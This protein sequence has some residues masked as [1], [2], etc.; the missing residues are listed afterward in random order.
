MNRVR[1]IGF[2]LIELLVV[3]VVLALLLALLVPVG[4]SAWNTALAAKCRTNLASM[5]QAQNTWRADRGADFPVT[6]AAWPMLLAPYLE[7]NDAVFRCPAGPDRQILEEAGGGGSGSAGGAAKKRRG[8]YLG[9][10]TFRMYARRDFNP[11][12]T[13]QYLGTA[14]VDS[15]YGVKKEHLGGGK[16]HYGVDDRSFF[17]DKS[18][19]A[20]NLDY[21]DMR[22]HLW[23]ENEFVTQMEII[24][25]DEITGQ[26]SW[27]EFR[28]EIWISDE[29]I[30]NDFVANKGVIFEMP[31]YACV[32]SFDYALNRGLYDVLGVPTTRLDP[33]LF[34]LL[35]YGKSLADYASASPDPWS[36]YFTLERDAWMARHGTELQSG[37]DWTF[38]VAP[39][40]L[41]T[42]NVLFADGH[43]EA[44]EV[45][46]LH[47]LDPRWRF[48][49][50]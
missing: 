14:F 10:L 27:R 33:R 15:S 42:A 36:K 48:G 9:D 11:Y 47:E 40:H 12:K 35:D 46:A 32:T 1:R 4:A 28:F 25:S 22:F 50:R 16:W 39:R 30:C 31:S 19:S 38:Y 8:I 29:M 26:G 17:L 6:G 2:S 18:V 5:W 20:G 3:I 44:L 43:I 13:G 34:F 7:N 41:G 49:P 37:E 21:A 45:D 23:I 24:G